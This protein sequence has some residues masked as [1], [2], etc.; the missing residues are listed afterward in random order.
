MKRGKKLLLLTLVLVLMAGVALAARKLTPKSKEADTGSKEI[1]IFSV[2]TE[3]VTKLT[4]TYQ[5]ETVA[6]VDAGDGWM[7][8]NDRDFPLD[9]SRLNTMLNAL[10]E[11]TP[12]K[13]SKTWRTL[14]STAWRSRFAASP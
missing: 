5:G 1:S 9:E 11:I 12:P 14:A 3:S 6:L 2:D 4:W 8:E 10:G 7:Y 13:P